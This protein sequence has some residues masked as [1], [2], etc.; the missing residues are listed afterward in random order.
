[1]YSDNSQAINETM[2]PQQ[3]EWVSLSSVISFLAPLKSRNGAHITHWG[4]QFRLVDISGPRMQELPTKR[5]KYAFQRQIGFSVKAPLYDLNMI[6][7]HFQ[8]G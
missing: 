4:I 5:E 2:S 1:M 3:I 7:N 6:Q 8:E